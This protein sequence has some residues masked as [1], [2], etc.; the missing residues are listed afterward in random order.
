[1]QQWKTI[2]LNKTSNQ[3]N[4]YNIIGRTKEIKMQWNKKLEK[5]LSRSLKT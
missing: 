2:K 1:M 3:W 5:N 4:E